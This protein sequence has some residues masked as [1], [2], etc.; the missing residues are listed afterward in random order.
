MNSYK[1]VR[2]PAMIIKSGLNTIM[3]ILNCDLNAM[4]GLGDGLDIK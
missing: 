2:G 3:V 4:A 1:R